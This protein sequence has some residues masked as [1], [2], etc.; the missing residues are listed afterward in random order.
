M[1]TQGSVPFAGAGV[2]EVTPDPL[3]G[4]SWWHWEFLAKRASRGIDMIPDLGLR[5]H[6]KDTGRGPG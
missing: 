4:R 3:P 6:R 2:E 1:S 5:W